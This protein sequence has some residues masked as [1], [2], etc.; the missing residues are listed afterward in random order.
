M[1]CRAAAPAPMPVVQWAATPSM[2]PGGE[3]RQDQARRR[4]DGGERRQHHCEPSE[5]LH[6]EAR[7]RS[8]PAASRA[9]RRAAAAQDCCGY[10]VGVTSIYW[11]LENYQQTSLECHLRVEHIICGAF[12][13][14]SE[15]TAFRAI[16]RRLK[17]EPGDGRAY[18]LTNLVHGVGSGRQPDEIDMVVIAPGGAVVIEVKHW[19]RG[20]LKA[21]AWE[22]DDEA[23][24]ITL[25]AK[26]IAT[27]LRRVKSDLAFVRAT[28]LL[29]KEAKSLFENGRLRDVRGVRLHALADVDAL[30]AN[31]VN[32]S[33]SS[34]DLE[35]LAR[36]LAPREAAAAAGEVRRIGRVGELKLL[37]PPAD[38]FQRVFSGRDSSNGDRV[39]LYLYDLSASNASNAEQLARR[40]FEAVQRLQKS[41]VLPSLVESFQP[42]PG[43]QGELFFFTLAE[44]A[45]QSVAEAA[46]DAEWSTVAR[47]SFAISAVR[48][49]AELQAPSEPEGQT[50]VHRALT[51][52]SVRVRADGQALFA[53]WRWAR[54]PRALSI[55]E[56]APA[57]DS[58]YAAPE[59]RK[60][61]LAFADARSD[62]YSLSKVLLDLFGGNDADAANAR[63]ALDAGLAE[64]PS[65]RAK[66]FAGHSLRSGGQRQDV[67]EG[68]PRLQRGDRLKRPCPPSRRRGAPPPSVRASPCPRHER[69]RA[70]SGATPSP[71]RRRPGWRC[72]PMPAAGDH[73]DGRVGNVDTGPSIVQAASGTLRGRP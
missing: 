8:M 66:L 64:E 39:T 22:V 59:V 2:P 54:L 31:V 73:A 7:S 68:D 14:A 29:T 5:A 30:L 10:A 46:A 1:P 36:T 71:V 28:M 17:A 50:V 32:P 26:R 58:S 3:R 49:L 20:R 33:G 47:L 23:D 34:L 60:N 13:N 4:R 11:P 43:Y 27:Q 21:H 15:E 45:A 69:R 48:A 44:S 40:E 24:L 51:P 72:R 12:A 63:S 61:G 55:A 62:V 41:P 52:D 37:S 25:K 6:R 18:I 67:I 16:E 56:H 70:W 57:V 38:R 42:V 53:G 65:A 35:R 19:D 9:P